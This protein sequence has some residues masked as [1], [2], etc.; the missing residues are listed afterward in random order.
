[1]TTKFHFLTMRPKK[2]RMVATGQ[3]P[4]ENTCP[5]TVKN[6]PAIVFIVVFFYCE[7]VTFDRDAFVIPCM[8]VDVIKSIGNRENFQTG[9]RQNQPCAC[10][11]KT[12]TDE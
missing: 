6:C 4:D 7:T 5:V 12:K 9:E 1:M 10:K 2:Q 8:T 3:F 11:R